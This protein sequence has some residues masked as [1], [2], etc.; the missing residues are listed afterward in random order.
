M[1]GD[2]DS[3][4]NDEDNDDPKEEEKGNVST[5]PIAKE[6][7]RPSTPPPQAQSKILK[8][9]ESHKTTEPENVLSE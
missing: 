5:D 8:I 4:D 1:P 2:L 6:T 3:Q 7:A 9:M